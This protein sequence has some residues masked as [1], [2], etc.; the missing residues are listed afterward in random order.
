[1]RPAGENTFFINFVNV[2]KKIA[3]GSTQA[4]VNATDVSISLEIQA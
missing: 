3:V 2:T 4:V 1:M